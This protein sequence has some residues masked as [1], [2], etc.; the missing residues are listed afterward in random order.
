MPRLIGLA[1]AL[2]LAFAAGVG[3]AFLPS[4]LH[5]SA[6]GFS[7]EETQAKL[8]RRVKLKANAFSSDSEFTN[9]GVVAYSTRDHGER[10]LV[11]DWDKKLPGWKHRITQVD[12]NTYQKLIAED[13]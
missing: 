9:T 8:G 12:R 13:R 3:S 11:I 7:H 1:L 4:L 10:V 5:R 2:T 6:E